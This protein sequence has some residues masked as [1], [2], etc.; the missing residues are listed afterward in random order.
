M[1]PTPVSPEFTK[2]FL[3]FRYSLVETLFLVCNAVIMAR[4]TNL[5]ILKD[6]LPQLLGNE[7]TVSCSHYK[8]LI[9]FFGKADPSNGGSLK[10]EANFPPK[11]LN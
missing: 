8:R 7:K 2:Y 3:D 6:Y 11:T 5:N 9:R 1:K 4:T 10:F